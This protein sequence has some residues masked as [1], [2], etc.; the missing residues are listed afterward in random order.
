MST[1]WEKLPPQSSQVNTVVG[2]KSIFS[3]IFFYLLSVYV[4]MFLIFLLLLSSWI[5]TW[6]YDIFRLQWLPASKRWSRW[7][8]R[9]H[10]PRF[11]CRL[12][13]VFKDGTSGC[14][15]FAKSDLCM[16][17]ICSIFN[18]AVNQAHREGC[19]KIRDFLYFECYQIL[20][21]CRFW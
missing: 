19:C 7:H 3:P 1:A 4:V 20:H 8:S 15:S 6:Y 10:C 12:L 2:R 5:M 18:S 17:L 14:Y 16:E 9:K 13:F 11:W 21:K